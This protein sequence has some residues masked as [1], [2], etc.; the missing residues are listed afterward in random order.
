MLGVFGLVFY[1]SP[2]QHLGGGDGHG[3]SWFGSQEEVSN[4][5]HGP[6]GCLGDGG[7]MPAAGAPH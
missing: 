6:S 2:K 5:R 7:L 4:I 1:C 3:D